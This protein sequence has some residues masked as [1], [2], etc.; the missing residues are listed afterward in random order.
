MTAI[1][2]AL[3][4]LRLTIEKQLT[5]G[6]HPRNKWFITDPIEVA[7]EHSEP[8]AK[9][10]GAIF[11]GYHD[12]VAMHFKQLRKDSLEGVVQYAERMNASAIRV[13]ADL[14]IFSYSTA[15]GSDALHLRRM[16]NLPDNALNQLGML[17]KQSV[18][19]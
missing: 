19:S 8:S 10:W 17:F 9:E 14:K 18:A 7:K 2:H 4:P 6:P 16:A 15:I 11:E 1:D 12:Q 13:R 3:P 5:T